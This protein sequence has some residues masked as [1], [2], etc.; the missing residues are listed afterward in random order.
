M[1]FFA[2][3]RLETMKSWVLRLESMAQPMAPSEES[4]PEKSDQHHPGKMTEICLFCGGSWPIFGEA[5]MV[6]RPMS[7]GR[8]R[9][10]G[11]KGSICWLRQVESMRSLG[12][13]H[14]L[15]WG[16]HDNS[17]W[18]WGCQNDIFVGSI[19]PKIRISLRHC[20]NWSEKWGPGHAPT[21]LQPGPVCG[22]SGDFP[23]S[24]DSIEKI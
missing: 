12:R 9:A 20:G 1:A 6:W 19:A 15:I 5:Q 10:R 3:Q 24:P 8:Q 16:F 11:E 2:R 17:R 13:N 4:Y 23:I 7:H 14:K 22:W 18:T 21:I